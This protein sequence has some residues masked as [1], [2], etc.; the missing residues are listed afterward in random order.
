MALDL[1]ERYGFSFYDCAIL[2]SALQAGCGA[3]YTED[4]QDGQVIEG[5]LLVRNPFSSDAGL[6]SL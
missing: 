1:S 2:A 6:Q 4:L 3:V 5:R